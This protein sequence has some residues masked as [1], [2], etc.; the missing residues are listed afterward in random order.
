MADGDDSAVLEVSSECKSV[1]SRNESRDSITEISNYSTSLEGSVI[2]SPSVESFS[3]LPENNGFDFSLD[4]KDLQVRVDNP[5]KHLDPFE[6][7]ISFRITTKTTR[8][9]FSEKEYV[10]R[11]RYS[12]F[13]WLRQKLVEDHPSHLVPAIPAKHTLLGQLDRYSKDFVIC[14]M[15]MLN[16]Y[17]NR[18]VNHPI[19]SCNANLKTFLTAKSTE[20]SSHRKA[21]STSLLN[22]M[23]DSLQNLTTIYAARSQRSAE[24]DS[25]GDHV[26]TL[27]EKLLAL[28]QVGARIY[29]E[30]KEWQMESALMQPILMRW[31][32]SEA[33]NH[34]N[35]VL[36]SVASAIDSCT[37]AHRRNIL[38]TFNHDFAQPLTEY[39]M[40]LDAIKEALARRDAIQVE[41]EA[42]VDRMA[43]KRNE[44]D[45]LMGGGE[46]AGAGSSSGFLGFNLWKSGTE[47]RE[48]RLEKLGTTIPKL[49]KQ[50]ELN[51]D[52]LEIANENLRSDLHRWRY[53]KKEDLKKILLKMADNH[54]KYYQEC[55]SAWERLSGIPGSYGTVSSHMVPGSSS[56]HHMAAP[57]T[58]SSIM[59]PG[60]SSSHHM[61]SG[62]VSSH[63]VVFNMV[64]PRTPQ[65]TDSATVM[66]MPL[67]AST[68]DLFLGFNL[69]KSGTE[70]RE[71]RLEKL[72]T[73]IPKLVKQAELNQDK[74]EIANENLRSD[75]HRWRYEK[76]E[77]LKKILLKM[78]D[79]HV[80]YY[81]ECLSAWERLSGIPGSY[82]TV[83]SHM[84][85]GSSSSHH[86]AAPGTVSS[87]MAPGSSSSHHMAS[88]TVSSHQVVF[89]MVEPR[90]PQVTDSATVMDMPLVASTDDLSPLS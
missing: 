35:K 7:Y 81:Q 29:K 72:G 64:E 34:M 53:E 57:G 71:D 10:V 51:Q 31:A 43:K 25:A 59:A 4:S 26:A 23:S 24:F 83:S 41:Y 28:K 11:R 76:K 36:L 15:T 65:V 78:A 17:M 30:R 5:Q 39:L 56:S 32:S 8:E 54:V 73:T 19:L 88:G 18:V 33:N 67:V 3:L 68:D 2:A 66:D 79:N 84:V 69:W 74:L 70:A 40:Y 47:A 44:K 49:V 80:K 60:S 85:P 16:R 63:Q 62:T 13:I 87:I 27:S 48:D 86:M 75:L 6:T 45:N 61:A 77:D 1:S 12:D 55:L 90:T 21:V 89:N 82:G 52:K 9:E 42:T 22:R 20:F 14:R 38:D 46:G 50:A 58:V 37:T